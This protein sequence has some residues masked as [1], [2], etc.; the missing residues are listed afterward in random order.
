MSA[1]RSGVVTKERDT[2]E[3]IGWTLSFPGFANDYPGDAIFVYRKTRQARASALKSLTEEIQNAT[4]LE[5]NG[6]GPSNSKLTPE[7]QL[8]GDVRAYCLQWTFNLAVPVLP[9][10]EYYTTDFLK[11]IGGTLSKKPKK[12]R[13]D[14]AKL[15]LVDG[16][17]THGYDN[18]D[19]HELAAF[20]NAINGTDRT[21]KAV[22]TEYVTRLGLPSKREPG[23]KERDWR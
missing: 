10:L 14:N 11:D 7:E 23:P 9:P 5:L 3:E 4:H 1:I 17:K 8:P 22:W 16:W 21:P 6:I 13:V 2:A 20:V 18:M 19:R 12:L 15:I